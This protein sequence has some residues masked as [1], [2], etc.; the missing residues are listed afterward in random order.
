MSAFII[1][2]YLRNSSKPETVSC[3]CWAS[4]SPVKEGPD[5]F[6]QFFCNAITTVNA[7]A[8][9][10]FFPWPHLLFWIPGNQAISHTKASLHIAQRLQNRLSWEKEY[11]WHEKLLSP[12]LALSLTK[13][14]QYQL[15]PASQPPVVDINKLLINKTY[16]KY[17]QKSKLSIK[18][19]NNP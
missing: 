12:N 14:E 13:K 19:K 8:Q 1:L 5:F 11:L 7:S 2:I 17:M 3:F 16:Q 9:I 15:F 18:I 6:Q 10:T 4:Y